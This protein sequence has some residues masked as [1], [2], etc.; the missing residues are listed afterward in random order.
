MG[1]CSA[2]R[3]GVVFDVRRACWDVPSLVWSRVLCLCPGL[4]L[5]PFCLIFPD[6]ESVAPA[7]SVFSGHVAVLLKEKFSERTECARAECVSRSP[8]R[9]IR[10]KLSEGF[11]GLGEGIDVSEFGDS[12]TGGREELVIEV[13]VAAKIAEIEEVTKRS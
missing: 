7:R 10:V 9:Y 11:D 13:Y 2:V 1:L 4:C 5:C 12:V 8:C 6:I 3:A